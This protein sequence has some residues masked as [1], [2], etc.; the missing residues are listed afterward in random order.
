MI[1]LKGVRDQL[2]IRSY[3]TKGKKDTREIDIHPKLKQY[4]KEYDAD[5]PYQK[6]PYLF[7]GRWGRGHIK[8]VSMDTILRRICLRLEIEGVSCVYL[9]V[10]LFICPANDFFLIFHLLFFWGISSNHHLL[11]HV[12]LLMLVC[13]TCASFCNPHIFF[14]FLYELLTLTVFIVM[15][16]LFLFLFIFV[17]FFHIFAPL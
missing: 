6:K 2:V 7:P 11:F 12:F 10:Y 9:F 14:S 16:E 3:N 13:F 15:F 8:K 1:G 17:F 5:N 4:L